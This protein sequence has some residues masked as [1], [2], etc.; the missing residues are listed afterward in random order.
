MQRLIIVYNPRSSKHAKIEDKVIRPAMRLPGY[1][2]GKFEVKHTPLDVNAI[3]LSKVIM[4]GDL[5]ISAGG[6]GTSSV[7]LNGILL[8]KKNATLAVL[9]FGNFND[10]AR[11]LG[12][13]KIDEIIDSFEHKADDVKTL[14]PLEAII[15]NEHYRYAACYFTIGMFA[16]STEIFDNKSTRKSLK[17]G[18]KGLT[19][20]IM[21]LAKWYFKN[22]R[23]SFLADDIKLNNAA[24]NTFKLL[25]S[26]NRS[27]IKGGK[28][29]DIIFVNGK[30]VAKLMK[31]GVFW[32]HQTDFLLSTPKLTSFVRLINFMIKSI[33]H[34][35]PGEIVNEPQKITFDA[36]TEIEIQGEGEYQTIKLKTLEVKKSQTGI[37]V[38]TK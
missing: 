34:Q 4:D 12:Y 18:R 5:I 21:Q 31:G 9:G 30:T 16:E 32:Q 28:V 38:L 3:N 6:D 33:F 1:M 23:K 24:L 27:I 20:S 29:S 36:P 19:Y 25:K 17:T 35:I 13:K 22:K 7:A 15:D 14:Y 37:K 8:S 11:T 26:G 2:V 10:F